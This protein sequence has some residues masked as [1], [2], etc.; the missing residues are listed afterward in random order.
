M[1]QVGGS[2][3]RYFVLEMH[4]NSP[5]AFDRVHA[6]TVNVSDAVLDKRIVIGTFGLFP[7][8]RAPVI[9][10]NMTGLPFL[11]RLCFIKLIFFVV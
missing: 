8:A 2:S 1:A 11:N 7:T 6:V 3:G 5:H 9:P 4:G 10:P